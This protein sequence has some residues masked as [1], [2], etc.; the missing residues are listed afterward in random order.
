[1][2]C[3]WGLNY[4]SWKYVSNCIDTKDAKKLC[5]EERKSLVTRD[6][7]IIFIFSNTISEIQ[8]NLAPSIIG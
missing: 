8:P 2:G 7:T 5:M 1:M 6:H 3:G 4:P